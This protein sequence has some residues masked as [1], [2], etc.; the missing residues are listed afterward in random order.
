MEIIDKIDLKIIDDIKII[1]LANNLEKKSKLRIFFE[2][3]K[4][5]LCIPFYPDNNQ[6][7]SKIAYNFFKECKI[8]ISSENINLIISRCNGDRENLQNELN[9][10]KH[11][12]RTKKNITRE[13]I[14]QLTNLIENI[15]SKKELVLSRISFSS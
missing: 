15:C 13:D 11:F 12:S 2:K 6:T 1:I 8:V 4:I 3:N 5:Y 10:I 14:A 9:K 7:L